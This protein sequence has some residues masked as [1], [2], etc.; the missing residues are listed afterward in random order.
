M[1]AEMGNVECGMRNRRRRRLCAPIRPSAFRIPHS[2]LPRSG[3]TLIEVILAMVILAA[4]LAMLGE[5]TQLA[6]RHATETRSEVQAQTLAASVMDQI[7]AG[8]IEREGVAQQALEVDD[9]IP[10]VYTIEI[11][12]SSIA[13]VI[14]V[15]VIVEQDIEARLS[16]AKFRLTRWTP[17]TLET[18][19]SA[20]GAVGGAAGGAAGAG[21][22]AGGAAGGAGGAFGGGG[23]GGGFGAGGG[24]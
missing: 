3:F 21:G 10:W 9:D 13:G 7:L 6:S 15:T 24:R 2:A 1:R 8:A 5:I 23:A 11:G 12:T 18:P 20:G 17:E 16:P 14:P 4:G 19:E 22:G